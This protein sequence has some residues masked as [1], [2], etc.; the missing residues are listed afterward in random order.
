MFEIIGGSLLLCNIEVIRGFSRNG[1]ISFLF[2]PS[3]WSVLHIDYNYL[4]HAQ[5]TLDVRLILLRVHTEERQRWRS[6]LER[7]REQGQ[8][9]L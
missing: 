1:Q 2:V 9:C 5:C 3:G 7:E 8:A 6:C 4:V